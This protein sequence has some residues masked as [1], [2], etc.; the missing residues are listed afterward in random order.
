MLSTSVCIRKGRRRQADYPGLGVLYTRLQLP[1]TQRGNIS[2]GFC[3]LSSYSLID[4][5]DALPRSFNTQSF[6]GGI[7][8]FFLNPPFYGRGKKRKKKE[9]KKE[10]KQAEKINRIKKKQ[11]PREESTDE[12]EKFD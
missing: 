7:V 1:K 6:S 10:K 2:V 12:K 5:G 4:F 9:R 8:I 3:L 11:I